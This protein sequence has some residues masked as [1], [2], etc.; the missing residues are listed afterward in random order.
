[1]IEKGHDR[2]KKQV[3]EV[4]WQNNNLRVGLGKITGYFCPQN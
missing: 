2:S 1:M 3:T 4:R